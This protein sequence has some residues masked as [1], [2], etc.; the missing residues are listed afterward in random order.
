MST[1]NIKGNDLID[2]KMNF[3]FGISAGALLAGI[4][5]QEISHFIVI[6]YVQSWYVEKYTSLL[7]YIGLLLEFVSLAHLPLAT[8]V[9]L[10]SFHILV[11]KYSLVKEEKRQLSPSESLGNTAI[12]AGCLVILLFGPRQ[13]IILEEEFSELFDFFYYIYCFGSLFC[14]L[15]LRRFGWFA[16]RIIVETGIVS[17]VNSFTLTAL[18]ILWIE[19]Q[20]FGVGGRGYAGICLLVSLVGT[21]LSSSLIRGLQ[22]DN[23]L[24]VIMGGYYIW[25]IFYTLPLSLFV[26]SGIEVTLLN[27]S[28]LIFSTSLVIPGVYLHSFTRIEYLKAYKEGKQQKT[29][30]FIV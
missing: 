1:R 21:F 12:L 23:D 8:Y 7:I 10:S 22:Q 18:K 26:K 25:C 20:V 24:V 6:S 29:P 28:A 4:Y 11:F 9:I 15:V 14:T 3:L 19:L 30:D 13:D 2:I 5:L 16:G 27:I 17:Q